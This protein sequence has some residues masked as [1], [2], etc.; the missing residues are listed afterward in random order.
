VLNNLFGA[1]QE[2]GGGP[3]T[4]TAQKC[5]GRSELTRVLKIMLD[6]ISQGCAL[7]LMKSEC[8]RSR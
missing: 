7:S 1:P 4:D 3:Q 2:L 6:G 8:N 5:I